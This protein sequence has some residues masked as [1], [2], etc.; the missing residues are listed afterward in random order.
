VPN[1]EGALAALTRCPQGL[2]PA[3]GGLSSYA[4]NFEDG[5]RSAGIYGRVLKGDKPADLRVTAMSH[6]SVS[7]IAF[8]TGF[9]A[10][11]HLNRVDRARY[12]RAARDASR[13]LDGAMAHL[14]SS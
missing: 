9:K 12:R 8:A 11:S 2:V 14:G 3:V 7:E 10:P 4:A 6:R 5:Y 1:R 13:H